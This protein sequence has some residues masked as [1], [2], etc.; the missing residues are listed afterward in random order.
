MTCHVWFLKQDCANWKAKLSKDE[1]CDYKWVNLENM[2][3]PKNYLIDHSLRMGVLERMASKYKMKILM[4]IG[5]N[6]ESVSTPELNLQMGR[7]LWGMTL[8]IWSYVLQMA[9]KNLTKQKNIDH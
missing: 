1:L 2:L 7:N 3:E 9:C 6:I 4:D 8:W 5:N